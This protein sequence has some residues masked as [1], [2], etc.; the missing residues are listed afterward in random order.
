VLGVRGYSDE[1]MCSTGIQEHP[2]GIGGHDKW[3]E[4]QYV[5]LIA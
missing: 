2:R 3:Y 5:E 1:G 4:L